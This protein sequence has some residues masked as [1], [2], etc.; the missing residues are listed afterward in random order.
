[1]S[2]VYV[3]MGSAKDGGNYFYTFDSAEDAGLFI[4]QM[5][6]QEFPKHDAFDIKWYSIPQ[7]VSNAEDAISD[8]TEWVKQIHL[9]TN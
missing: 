6:T 8:M 4:K 9:R 2:T 5:T 7:I 3:V 1:M